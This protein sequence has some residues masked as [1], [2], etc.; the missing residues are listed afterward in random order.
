M[1]TLICAV[2]AALAV[3]G[4]AETAATNAAAKPT[5][6][7]TPEQIAANRARRAAR[8]AARIA[9][10]GGMITKPNSGNFIRVVSAQKKIPLDQIKALVDQFNTGLC[11]WTE[12]SEIE[13]GAT[14]FETLEKARKLPK[15]GLLTLVV[16][17]DKC[18]VILSAMEECW[19]I[20][21]IRHLRDD[22]PP[23]DVYENRIRKE[24]NRA[25]AQSA[26]AGISYNRPCALEPALTV[27]QL[28]ALKFP[29]MSPE[30]LSKVQEVGNL[31]GVDR[32]IGGTYKDACQEGWAPAPTND[33]QKALWD[34][35][36]SIPSNPIKIKFDPKRDAGK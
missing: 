35:V 17:D 9:A 34:E 32:I 25:V 10:E 11:M 4:L 28:D 30:A 31:R 5:K 18:P 8:I 23:K 24:L 12:V 15:T 16:D 29:V 27:T 6:K 14:P 21:N 1:K 26:G 20:L 36:H 33:V 19:S 3:V 7:F 2:L 13:P 22:L